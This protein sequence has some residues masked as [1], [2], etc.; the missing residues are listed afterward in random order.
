M[1][2]KYIQP[3]I[4][5]VKSDTPCIIA[6]SEPRIDPEWADPLFPGL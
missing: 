4:E 2:K 1:K 6:V 5:I 3:T